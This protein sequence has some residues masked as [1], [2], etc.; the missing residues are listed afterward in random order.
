M[1]WRE[2]YESQLRTLVEKGFAREVSAAD[3]KAWEQRGGKTYFIA[4]QM[5]IN[6]QSKT[7]PVR[8][9]FNSSQRYKGYSLNTS[10]ELG[11]DLVNS[12]HGILLRFRKD[13]VAAQGDITKMYYMV[14]IMEEESWMQLFMWKF[15][16]EEKLRYFKMERLVMGNKPSASL[17][18]VALAETANLED[19]SKRFPA[20]HKALTSDAYVD[21]IFLTAPTHAA[22]RKTIGEIELVAAKGGFFFKP[23]VVSGDNQPDSIIGVALPDTIEPDEEKALGVYW[24]IQGDT[25]YVK[26]D[27][28]KSGRGVKGSKSASLVIIDPSSRVVITPHLT[29]RVCLSLH[30]RPFDPLGLI[31]PTKVIGNILFR[32]TLQSMKKDNKGKIPWDEAIEGEVKTKWCDYFLC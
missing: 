14:R 23:F 5:V 15:H 24:D 18:G 2:V 4:H 26:A 9:C 10:W 1:E 31:L 11:P 19:F 25:L 28:V 16:G 8:C 12:L 6:P 13:L 20:A 17:S 21:N 30:A 22:I 27:L 29:L 7:T 3:I 32:S